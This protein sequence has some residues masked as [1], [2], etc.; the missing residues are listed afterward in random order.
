[1]TT[2]T[3]FAIM[4]GGGE[5]GRGLGGTTR[6][7]RRRLS[8]PFRLPP[9]VAPVPPSS[10]AIDREKISDNEEEKGDSVVSG[11]T[12]LRVY[13]G[14][15][16]DAWDDASLCPRRGH[17][18]ARALMA[19]GEWSVKNTTIKY[20]TGGWPPLRRREG[21]RRDEVSLSSL[22]SSSAIIH[23]IIIL[24]TT[25]VNSDQNRLYIYICTYNSWYITFIEKNR[26][27]V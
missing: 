4:Y 21:E 6:R 14:R 9:P 7:R 19:R 20:K 26:M 5:T 3:T 8:R 15:R 24:P 17:R 18:N 16:V 11:T 27:K 1:M 10:T 23:P 12:A 2:M 13:W 25:I 22:L